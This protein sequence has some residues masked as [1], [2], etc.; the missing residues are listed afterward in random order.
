MKL[1]KLYWKAIN[2]VVTYKVTEKKEVMFQ[3]K[4]NDLELRNI[5]VE[6]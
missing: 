4:G 1:A 6:F 2:E 3:N 5:I